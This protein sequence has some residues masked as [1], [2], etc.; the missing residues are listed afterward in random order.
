LVTFQTTVI[1]VN[2]NYGEN[3]T[4]GQYPYCLSLRNNTIS[5]IIASKNLRQLKKFAELVDLLLIN[6]YLS[7]KLI[8]SE[9]LQLFSENEVQKQDFKEELLDLIRENSLNC[10]VHYSKYKN[11]VE[12]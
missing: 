9:N 6:N 11:G 12:Q 7:G 5:R 2:P 1:H 4:L 10:L 3:T 8:N